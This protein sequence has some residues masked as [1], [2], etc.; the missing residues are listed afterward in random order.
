[1]TP[2]SR[3]RRSY[4][5]TSGT[6]V[7]SASTA[8][9]ASSTS[10]PGPGFRARGFGGSSRSAAN[11]PAS[12]TTAS[13]S[14]S[15]STISWSSAMTTS[16]SRSGCRPSAIRASSSSASSTTWWASAHAPASVSR[17][18]SGSRPTRSALSWKSALANAL[19]VETS[20]CRSRSTSSTSPDRASARSAWSMRWASSPAAFRVK[21]SPSTWSGRTT[22]LATSQTTRRAIVSVLPAPAP[23]MTSA[24]RSSANSMTARCSGVGGYTRTARAIASAPSGGRRTPAPDAPVVPTPGAPVVPAPAGGMPSFVTSRFASIAAPSP[25]VVL[26]LIAPPASAHRPAPLPPSALHPRIAPRRAR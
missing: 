24:G 1:M 11:R 20:G 21:V 4:S 2:R 8:S 12:A 10:L 25:I 19:Y 13:G 15:L 5:C 9:T 26:S 23:A 3:L 18:E 22:R 17:V 14:T 7:S 6:S 16:A